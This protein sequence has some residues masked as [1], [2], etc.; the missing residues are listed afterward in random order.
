[1]TDVNAVLDD[2]GLGTYHYV[3]L[4]VIGGIQL[5]DGA[6][7][8]V[9]S[10][11][12]GS[13]SS[14]WGLSNIERGVMMSCIFI[15]VCTGGL[16]GGNLADIFGRRT[17][18]L[19]SYCGIIGFGVGT[20]FSNGPWS[21][22]LLRF[23]FGASFGCGV[24]PGLAIL[25]ETAPARARAHIVN[26]GSI[27]FAV[28]EIYTSVLLIVFMPYLTDTAEAQV[29]RRLTVL[30]IIPGIMLFP[31]AWLLLRESPHYLLTRGREQEAL[32]TVKYIAYMNGREDAVRTLEQEIGADP[33]AGSSGLN[34]GAT[35]VG[36]RTALLAGQQPSVPEDEVLSGSGSDHA[37]SDMG[38]VSEH[39]IAACPIQTA[40][41]I[42]E[43][44]RAEII[45]GPDL[46]LI[47]IGGCYL[48]FLSNFTF[49]G[50]TY[51]M[52][53]VLR[54]LGTNINPAQEV[55]AI[56]LCDLPGVAL[57]WWLISSK[58][59]GHRDG[60]ALMAAVLAFLNFALIGIDHGKGLL[61][62]GLVAAPLAKF[63]ASAFF[64]LSYVYLAE[65]FPSAVRCTGISMCVAAGRL[66]SIL[67]PLC[68]ETLS[69]NSFA[70]GSHAPYF[71][72]NIGLS[73]F[74]IVAIKSFL[75][76]ELKNAPLEDVPSKRPRPASKRPSL[77]LPESSRRGSNTES[78]SAS[79]GPRSSGGGSGNLALNDALQRLSLRRESSSSAPSLK[80][81]GKHND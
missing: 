15:G 1:M 42:T 27:F 68:F 45:F 41:H 55:L 36:E 21:M 48:C 52:P 18:S 71:I 81:L 63:V 74:A 35:V 77:C 2:I 10:S 13:L 64:T 57:G 8:L 25:V 24:G 31:L 32:E 54:E 65:I 30:S 20:A 66:G 60:L 23:F 46:R 4:L 75:T 38:S 58:S 28:G 49:Y 69:Q 17:M 39:P 78:T 26:M 3:Q 22:L 12:I 29:W 11:V 72:L 7:I 47:V 6:E 59:I 33:E 50:L 40:S 73:L 16:I 19:V 76:F 37:I 5:T 62:V 80:A 53:Q 61:W 44:E 14:I 79:G 34:A 51:A 70:I 67:S 43:K 9:S 56:S